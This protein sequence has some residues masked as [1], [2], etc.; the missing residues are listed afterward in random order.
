MSTPSIQ[1]DIRFIK[2]YVREIGRI[3]E[4][5][6]AAFPSVERDLILRSLAFLDG[7][8]ER[9][10][11]SSDEETNLT[12][13]FTTLDRVNKF[14][15]GE[16]EFGNIGLDER[17]IEPLDVPTI[18]HI[19]AVSFGFI[20]FWR[21]SLCSCL[22]RRTEAGNRKLVQGVHCGICKT[23]SAFLREWP[24]ACLYIDF[25]K[26]CDSFYIPFALL[27]C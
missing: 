4:N 10:S 26:D 1:D 23:R 20:P 27:P 12:P 7:P 15:T 5:S 9:I 2:H 21:D 14:L 19:A 22:T 6:G 13:N 18:G 16:I 11:D 24:Y 8:L 25:K 17:F 3:V